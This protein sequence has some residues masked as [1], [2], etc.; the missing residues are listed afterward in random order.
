MRI[1]RQREDKKNEIWWA[2]RGSCQE[3]RV[4]SSFRT[5]ALCRYIQVDATG[6][7][8]GHNPWRFVQLRPKYT[9]CLKKNRTT[10]INMT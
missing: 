10:M 7:D 3:E 1:E 8:A 4:E 9:L 5:V 2:G 6:R